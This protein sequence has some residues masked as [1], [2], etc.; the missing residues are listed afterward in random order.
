MIVNQDEPV[1]PGEQTSQDEPATHS[2]RLWGKIPLRKAVST[3]I[4]LPLFG[5]LVYN[6]P[7]LAFALLLCGIGLLALRE[8]A[9]MAGIAFGL[10]RLPLLAFGSLL[11]LAVAYLP[12]VVV[13][14]L[15]AAAV[16]LPLLLELFGGQAAQ[17]GLQ[18]VALSVLGLLYIGLL[19]GFVGRLRLL[20]NG[21]EV[22]LL[23]FLITWGG[24]LGAGLV[25]MLVGRHH[26]PAR[27]NARKTWEGVVGGLL[28]ALLLALLL[29]AGWQGVAGWQA[30]LVGLGLGLAGQVGDLGESLL[31]RSVG[32]SDSGVFLPGQGGVL[33]R[34]DSLL[35]AAPVCYGLLIVMGN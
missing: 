10:A 7:P 20:P 15:V 23:F 9:H 12:P 5:L 25:G 11:P 19:L 13:L 28:L 8:F 17:P 31:K 33:D 2:A 6:L 32:A 27:I 18:R 4:G 1:Q 24:D 21:H 29:L 16:L 14:L 35:V 30:L 26:L 34:I 22:V 3:V